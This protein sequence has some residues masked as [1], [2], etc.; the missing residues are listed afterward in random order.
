MI[1]L[2]YISSIIIHIIMYYYIGKQRGNTFIYTYSYTYTYACTYTLGKIADGRY[3][4]I[5]FFER[6][7][8]VC[9]YVCMNVYVCMCDSF[10]LIG[11]AIT[12]SNIMHVYVHM[13]AYYDMKK[14]FS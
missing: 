11:S 7:V 2:L 3:E 14:L 8:C 13:Y 12:T 9:M 6:Y 1:V 10:L 5:L 4:E